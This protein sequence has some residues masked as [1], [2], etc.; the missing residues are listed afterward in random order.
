V[1]N[2]ELLNKIAAI[3][4]AD[5][6]KGLR[7]LNMLFKAN[8]ED[9][10]EGFSIVDDPNEDMDDDA[11]KWLAEQE[12]E[13]A[14]EPVKDKKV[15]YSKDW[16]PRQNLTQ[17]QRDAVKEHMDSGYSEREAHRLAGAH[18]EIGDLQQAMRSGIKPSMM[19]DKMIDHVKG[20][21]KEWLDNHD[22][23]EKLNADI[24][25]NPMKHAAGK[26]LAAHD[27]HMGDHKRALNEFL[28]SDDM[29]GVSGRERHKKIQDWKKQYRE[30][31]PDHAERISNASQAQQSYGESRAAIKQ[32]L[33]EKLANIV[34]GG[35]FSPDETYSDKAGVQHAGI[36][37]RPGENDSGAATGTVS[38]DPLSSF[39]SQNQKLVG[40]L[41]DEQKERFNRVNSAAA[42]QGK[43][44]TI[45]R[46]KNDGQQ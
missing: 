3:Y 18:R 22:R 5:P 10:G 16:E 42:A 2:K 40:M 25:K 39:A 38:K 43:Q 36:Q 23:Y 8:E 32:N 21:A 7:L 19:S 9:L 35:G 37:L 11:A 30:Q 29:K 6:D 14:E 41:S 24:E 1:E 28:S 15:S 31:N 33:Q 34:S 4:E 46:R 26:M 27:E 44:R 12:S 13:V 45:V 20:L 17:E